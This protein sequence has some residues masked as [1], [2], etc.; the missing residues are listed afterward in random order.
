MP[1]PH[2]PHADAIRTARRIVEEAGTRLVQTVRDGDAQAV[3]DACHDLVVRIAQAIVDAE[4]TTAD[5]DRGRREASPDGT[6][7]P[8]AHFRSWPAT[9]SGVPTWASLMITAAKD[10]A[11]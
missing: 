3:S 5:Q 10:D 7:D 1:R 8:S 4:R 11:R 9:L 2:E 6:D